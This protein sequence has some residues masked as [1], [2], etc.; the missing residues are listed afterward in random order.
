M[1]LTFA[2]LKDITQGAVRLTCE[3]DTV[4]FF[5]FTDEQEALYHRTNQEF[6]TK[7][8]CTAGVKLQ[9]RTDSPWLELD[10]EAFQSMPNRVYYSFDVYA[11]RKRIGSLDNFSDRTLCGAYIFD[12]YPLGR[13]KK[14]FKLGHGEK[15]VS[16]YFPWTVRVDL[17]GLSLA[18]G[19][20]VIPVRPTKKLLTFGD[21]ITQGYDA[22]RPSCRYAAV[23]AEALGAEE[24][25][26][27]IGGEV[28]FPELAETREDVSPNYITVAYGTNDWSK[29]ERPV[30]LKNCREF[31]EALC[32]NYPQAKIY[33]LTPIW[34]KDRD[35]YRVYGSFD[36]VAQDLCDI[37]RNL[38]QVTVIP[39]YS[40][41]PK[42]STCFAD[43]RLHPND[44][45]FAAYAACLIDAIS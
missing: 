43:L 38:Q 19:A 33:A 24:F 4:R 5:R 3:N 42:D 20:S 35:E 25:C 9:F 15:T 18:D 44:R 45:G 34:R 26:K 17:H 12:D 39:C 14:R 23:L 41:V 29:T 1:R 28:F 6:Y 37:V 36:Q 30:F 31:F 2:Q 22:L 32:R 11:N 8:F 40:F 27:A 21:S 16:I 13:A 7:T 10:L